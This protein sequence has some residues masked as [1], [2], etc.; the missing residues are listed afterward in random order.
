[1]SKRSPEDQSGQINDKGMKGSGDKEH[2]E[3][4]IP[5]HCL[6]RKHGEDI[7]HDE[8]Q[9]SQRGCSKYE[10]CT[11][12]KERDFSISSKSSSSLKLKDLCKDTN[13]GSSEPGKPVDE[14]TKLVDTD[15]QSL[16]SVEGK[17]FV[18]LEIKD[19]NAKGLGD[20]H[21]D[22]VEKLKKKRSEWFKLPMPSEKEALVIKKLDSEP[23]PST[24]NEN[25]MDS[26]VKQERP[27]RKRR[28]ISN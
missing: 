17:D 6:S 4:E 13:D 9:D 23:L 15:D 27:A 19:T 11:S 26:E 16:I 8:Q 1:M 22:K 12:H 10:R 18:D 28:W 14:S 2:A 25:P 3:D 24:E 5:G 7:S 20:Q 21:L